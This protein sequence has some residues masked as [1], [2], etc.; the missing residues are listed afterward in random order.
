[1]KIWITRHGQTRLNWLHLMQ[2][3]TDEP[4]NE[5][6]TAQARAAR[7]Q[8]GDIRFDAVY[9]S[10]LVRAV[11]TAAI[12]GGVDISEVKIDER[13]IE[14]DFGRYEQKKYWCL[15]PAMSLYWALPE[16]FPAPKTVE[17]TASL[18]ERS[19]SFLQE[20]EQKDYEN[21]L[22]SCHGGIMRA[23]SGYLMDRKNGLYWRP[24]PHN[25]EIRVFEAENGKHRLL[26]IYPSPKKEQL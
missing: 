17:S 6:G 21:V 5:T 16:I 7:R 15:G 11:R 18:R 12:I 25:C 22:I 10:P 1:M 14:A 19:T 9:A 26:K 23:L 13:L 8:I 24:K 2:G 3:R 20:L 4:L